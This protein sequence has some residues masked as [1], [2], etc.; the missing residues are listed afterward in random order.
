MS[1]AKPV[2]IPL[3]GHF[4]LSKAHALTTKDEN[5]MSEVPYAAVVGSLMYIMV[6][7]RSN[8]SLSS[9]SCQKVYEQSR[10][11]TLERSKVDLEISEREFKHKIVL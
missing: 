9:E 8:I 3:Q 10:E 4:K 5:A 7:M 2:N 1:G 6:C 11:A